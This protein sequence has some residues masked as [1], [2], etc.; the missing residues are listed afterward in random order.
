MPLH[1]LKRQAWKFVEKRVVYYC[2]SEMTNNPSL[3]LT[4]ASLT[5][6]GWF[7]ATYLLQLTCYNAADTHFNRPERG[8]AVLLWKLH[9]SWQSG[10]SKTL[11]L[12]ALNAHALHGKANPY[13]RH[14]RPD[15]PSQV[16]LRPQVE[17]R[18]TDELSSFRREE[19]NRSPRSPHLALS[20]G[21]CICR[22]V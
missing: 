11:W 21:R 18:Q 7:L 19:A 9:V 2:A 3:T 1:N 14:N 6:S 16:S 13:P 15:L 20:A 5:T 8:T 12:S 17:I 4:I 10:R 22:L